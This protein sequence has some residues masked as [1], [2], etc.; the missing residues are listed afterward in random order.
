MATRAWVCRT[1]VGLLSSGRIVSR[2]SLSPPKS[3][4]DPSHACWS[5]RAALKLIGAAVA[6]G[7]RS[8]IGAPSSASAYGRSRGVE[9]VF[10]L[11]GWANRRPHRRRA[12]PPSS[13]DSA[14]V[15]PRSR[16]AS[17]ECLWALHIQQYSRVP[18]IVTHRVVV[19]CECACVRG[20]RRWRWL[21]C[22][23]PCL[24]LGPELGWVIIKWA[25]V[26]HPA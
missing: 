11:A 16:A 14:L 2:Y 6:E 19:R 12:D 9:H 8:Q 4:H 5:F 18:A 13:N 25:E 22:E 26:M 1:G 24:D 23:P 21:S 20:G 10:D 3:L 15:E 17:Y 7:S